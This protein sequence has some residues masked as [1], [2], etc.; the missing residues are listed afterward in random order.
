MRLQT[1]CMLLIMMCRWT[2]G[3]VRCPDPNVA[4]CFDVVATNLFCLS[5]CWVRFA[6][7]LLPPLELAAVQ[8]MFLSSSVTRHHTDCCHKQRLSGRD[9]QICCHFG[10]KLINLIFLCSGHTH[11]PASAHSCSVN[12]QQHHP[13]AASPLSPPL[14][15]SL[16]LTTNTSHRLWAC[17]FLSLNYNNFWEENTPII[18]KRTQIYQSLLSYLITEPFLKKSHICH[19]L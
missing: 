6:N 3:C 4:L 8:L 14:S 12:I 9:V 10:S 13:I 5:C 17:L 16:S 7:T 18:T 2:S 1:D 15:S 11:P 19:S